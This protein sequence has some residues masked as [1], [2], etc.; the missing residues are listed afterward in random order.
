L[1]N[2]KIAFVGAGNMANSLILGLLNKGTSPGNIAACDIDA[3]K[4]A[5][6]NHDCGINTGTLEEVVAGAN[7]VLL[8]VKPQ[9]MEQVCRTLKPLLS[10][11]SCLIISI[12]AG[13]PLHKFET[14]L[15]AQHAI[16]RCMP[17]TPA[18]VS[19]GATALFA[20]ANTSQEQSELAETI[21]AAVGI[22]SWLEN[23]DALNAVTALSGSGPAYYF[24]MMEAMEQAALQMGLSAQMAREFTIQ[25]AL[26]A[27]K[28]AANSDVAPDELR[29]RVTSP[30]GTTEAAIKHFEHEGFRELVAHAIFAAQKRSIELAD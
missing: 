6:L 26:G 9:V 5:Q 18:L 24:L 15:G 7:V 28:L 29:R 27:A 4:L 25:T 20:N 23:E 21:L 14:W 11:S 30:G 10:Q 3:N 8:A 22:C 1:K 13:I 16:V 12:A 19:E 2:S 17:N